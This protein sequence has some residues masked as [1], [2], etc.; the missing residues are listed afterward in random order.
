MHEDS[1]LTVVTVVT[2]A[3]LAGAALR[4]FSK[5]TGFPFTVAMLLLGGAIGFALHGGESSHEGVSG[6]LGWGEGLTPHLIV[7]VFLP[8]LVFESAFAIDVHAVRKNIGAILL[9]AVPALIVCTFV[10]AAMMVG[11]TASSWAWAWPAALV[12]GALTSATDPVAVVAVLRDVGAPKRLTVLIEG[13]SLANDGTAIVVFTVLVAALA[14]GDTSSLG[15][16]ESGQAFLRVVAGGV[17]VGFVFG[18]AATMWVARTFDDPLLE[19]TLT[20]VLAYASM[21]VAEGIFHV[22]GVLAVVTAGLFMSGPGRYRISPEVQ[23]F[24]HQ[25]WEL[26]AYIANAL[27]FF[28]VGAVISTQLGEMNLTTLAITL[29]A[30]V[31]M[32][33]I[34]FALTFGFLPLI[35]RV[36]EPVSAG[37]AT[38]MSWGGLRGAVSLAL[39]LAVSQNPAVDRLLGDQILQ[40]TAG[41][42]LLSILINGTSTGALLRRLGFDALPLSEQLAALRAESGV[43]ASV[44]DEVEHASRAPELRTVRWEVVRAD[45]EARA[46]EAR[47]LWAE[48]KVAFDRASP[49]ARAMGLWRRALAVELQAYRE[50]S[51]AGTL[52]N[53]AL[54]QLRREIDHHLDRIDR[55]DLRPPATRTSESKLR[56]LF[57]RVYRALGREFGGA[58]FM[59]LSQEYD[60]CRAEAHAAREVR[61]TMIKLR[62]ADPE[63]V[64]RILATYA[65]Y[66]RE[67]KESLEDIRV[68]LPEVA[69]T[70]ETRIARRIALN[71]ERSAYEDA[72]A[73]GELG[74]DQVEHAL[75]DVRQRMKH[76]HFERPRVSI[77][78][79]ADLCRTTD[80][81]ADLPEDVID[82]L[83]KMTVEQ[84]LPPGEHLFRAGDRGDALYIIARGAVHVLDETGSLTG[85]SSVDAAPMAVL[86]GGQLLGEMALL[87]GEPRAASARAATTVTLGRISRADFDLLMQ[88]RPEVR[89]RIWQAYGQRVFD[90][91][92]R[93][94]RR[95]A[96]LVGAPSRA[97]F[98]DGR[99][100][101]LA[102]GESRE[103]EGA[104]FAFVVHGRVSRGPLVFDAPALVEL[105]GVRL[106]ADR[107]TRL[108]LL[109]ETPDAEEEM[110]LE[111][112]ASVASA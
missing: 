35:N 102:E 20:L 94:D 9:L 1:E 59:R 15:L 53:A 45:V 41:V 50:A 58:E 46:A 55:G 100:L 33:L 95:R 78:E 79:T 17:A 4:A 66:E 104:R 8:A 13:E 72:L 57:A 51:A 85:I 44:A 69:S 39:A 76:L 27:I 61:E 107:P 49:Q 42:V 98:R 40:V 43:L 12:F 32:V 105:D 63:V 84:V 64:D 29:A 56:R 91:A 10:T 6:V 14:S 24:L 97:W 31:G 73:R 38:V 25:F 2:L 86:T 7:F 18:L 52:G 37:Q 68:N 74:A 81:F 90:N 36:G 5:R 62:D 65:A 111:P 21:V 34:R 108:Q 28:L 77:A 70:I 109:D 16:A 11:L 101:S 80:L 106:H 89:E 67:V 19:I 88:T 23:H 110:E 48:A 75:G 82:Q 26:L 99:P 96:P 71:A 30:Y 22:S 93:L 54:D 87:T 60:L 47:R 92:L 3:L 103:L 83:A 112:L